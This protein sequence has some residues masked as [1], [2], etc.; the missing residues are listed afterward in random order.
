MTAITNPQVVVGEL[1]TITNRI[2]SSRA[3]GYS[4]HNFEHGDEVEVRRVNTNRTLL[5]WN[6][7]SWW[8]DNGDL[9]AQD[10]NAPTPR[11]LGQVPEGGIDPNDPGLAWLWEDA[12]TLAKLHSYCSTYDFLAAQLGIPGRPR[13]FTVSRTI[14]GLTV[15]GTFMATS[16][17]A[18]NEQFDAAVVNVT[19]IALAAAPD[20]VTVD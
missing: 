8:V 15:K 13:N 2:R 16:Q 19:D 14:N 6:N 7:F 1:L 18:A 20:E 4:N 3:D 17:K 9:N 5:R 12:A 10:P 11:R